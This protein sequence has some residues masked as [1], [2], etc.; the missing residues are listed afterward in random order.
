MQNWIDSERSFRQG[1]ADYRKIGIR[2]V[3]DYR[4]G[5]GWTTA[6]WEFTLGNTHV[7]DRNIRVSG[8]RAH[9]IYWSAPS[10]RWNSAESRRIFD[11]AAASFVPAPVRN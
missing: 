10:S 6:D 1:R 4:P 9:A 3:P 7:L 2:R 11:L 8:S 5:S